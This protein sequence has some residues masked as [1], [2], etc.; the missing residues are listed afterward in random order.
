M[1][2]LVWLK[3]SKFRQGCGVSLG[4]RVLGE[5]RVREGGVWREV[6]LCGGAVWRGRHALVWPLLVASNGS[7]QELRTKCLD[8][9]N[10][11]DTR[12]PD[13]EARESFLP[14]TNQSTSTTTIMASSSSKKQYTPLASPTASYYDLSDND[15]A[16]Y[17]TITHHSTGRSVK[18]LYSKSKVNFPHR[19]FYGSSLISPRKKGLRAPFR[20]VKR[21]HPGLRS[22]PPPK[23][24]TE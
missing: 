17:N 6:G 16:E 15:E 10:A 13:S 14:R 20:L 3:K 22:S 5:W 12:Y 18:L 19:F 1:G 24:V 2:S 9:S 8:L 7:S 23:T 4:A 11:L 21:Q